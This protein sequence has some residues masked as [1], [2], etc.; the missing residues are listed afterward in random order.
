VTEDLAAL[1]HRIIDAER[2]MTLAT[3]D[4]DGRPWASPVYFAASDDHTDFYWISSPEATHSR[5]IA[6]RPE[7]SIVIFDSGIPVGEG[8]A[9]Y[10]AATV[11]R[12]DGADVEQGLTVYP[13]PPERCGDFRTSP[14]RLQAPGPYRLYRATATEHSMLCPRETGPCEH[15]GDAFDHRTQ[16]RL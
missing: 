3:A 13:G 15:H 12:L 11:A 1:A 4:A 9:V 8:Q 7:V 2:Y 16:V 10:I 14:D 6:V 5:N